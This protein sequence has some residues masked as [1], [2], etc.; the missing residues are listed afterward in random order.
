MA[1]R[2]ENGELDYLEIGG[3]DTGKSDVDGD[4]IEGI[5]K[6]HVATVHAFLA[7]GGGVNEGPA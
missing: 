5:K 3:W 1:I 7:K 6:G 4:L 2:V